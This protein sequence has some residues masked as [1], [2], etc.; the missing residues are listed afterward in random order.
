[1]SRKELVRRRKAKKEAIKNNQ[2]GESTAW[3]K[4]GNFSSRF[5]GKEGIWGVY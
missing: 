5:T 3:E 1:M 4:L 2:T